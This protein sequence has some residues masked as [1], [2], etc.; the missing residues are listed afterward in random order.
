[1]IPG[2]AAAMREAVREGVKFCLVGSIG[3]VPGSGWTTGN[4]HYEQL[5]HG[6]T[7]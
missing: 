6:I 7:R 1:M 5:L 4:C 2:R 3:A